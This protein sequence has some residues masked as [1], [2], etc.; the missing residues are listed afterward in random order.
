MLFFGFFEMRKNYFKI[1]KFLLISENDT[2]FSSK[3]LF[4]GKN[5]VLCFLDRNYMLIY[6][7]K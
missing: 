2:I 1:S 7:K 5:F 3:K 6:M 4:E